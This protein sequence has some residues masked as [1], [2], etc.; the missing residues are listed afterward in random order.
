MAHVGLAHVG[1]EVKALEGEVEKRILSSE[2]F[3][4]YSSRGNGL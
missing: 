1:F 3:F 4:P 2:V